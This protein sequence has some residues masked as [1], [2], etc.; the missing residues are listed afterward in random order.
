MAS[1]YLNL[2]YFIKSVLKLSGVTLEFLF[3]DGTLE[4]IQL[5]DQNK[6]NSMENTTKLKN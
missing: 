3:S 1:I 2:R 4:I 5:K 6:N